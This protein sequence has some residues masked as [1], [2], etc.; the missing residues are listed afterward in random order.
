MIVGVPSKMKSE[1][2]S[3]LVQALDASNPPSS[4]NLATAL[5]YSYNTHVP[6]DMPL[7]GHT[8]LPANKQGLYPSSSTSSNNTFGMENLFLGQSK[9]GFPASC[10]K[11]K[12]HSG[13]TLPTALGGSSSGG[14]SIGVATPTNYA[15]NSFSSCLGPDWPDLGITLG[16]SNKTG[17]GQG[18]STKTTKTAATT[19][20][21]DDKGAAAA[22]TQGAE[23]GGVKNALWKGTDASASKHNL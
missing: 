1:K 8:H 19:M 10:F 6:T 16:Q 17:G 20:S 15:A 5:N 7:H 4:H 18:Q 9:P 14:S 23:F 13:D 21:G 12:D 3:P 2:Q 11:V 22:A